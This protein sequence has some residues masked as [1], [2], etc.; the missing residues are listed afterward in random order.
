[1][2]LWVDDGVNDGPTNMARDAAYLECGE[3]RVRVYEWDR[4]WVSLGRFQVPEMTVR[5]G[6]EVGWVI[7]PTGGKAVL[8]GHDLTVGMGFPLALLRE[9][10]REVKAIYRRVIPVLVGALNRVGIPAILA[11]ETPFV[12]GAG[13]VADC[14]AHVSANDVVDPATGMKVCGCALRVTSDMVLV[15]ASIPVREPE[16]FAG[17]VFDDP[18]LPGQVWNV[19]RQDFS[20]AVGEEFEGLV[21]RCTSTVERGG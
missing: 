18:A 10:E 3:A 15:Q 14:F 8:H 9:S 7:R 12:R 5:A 20:V 2:S 1:M 17:E 13:K 19:R 6:C 16:V 4:P 21:A 11:E